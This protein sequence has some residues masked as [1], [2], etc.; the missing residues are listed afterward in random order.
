MIQYRSLRTILPAIVCLASTIFLPASQE[1]KLSEEQIKVFLRTAKVI[2]K[3]RTSTGVTSPYQLTLT[4]GTITHDAGFNYVNDFKTKMEFSDGRVENNFCDYYRYDIAAY[5]LAKLLGLDDMIPVTVERKALGEIGAISWWFPTKMNDRKRLE[6]KIDPPDIDAWNKQMYKKRVFAE[7]VYDN[8]PNLTNLLIS[9]DWQICM[10]DFTR[11]FR[12]HKAL[13]EVK[14]ISESMCERHLLERLRKL[15]RNEL[16]R[17]TKYLKTEYLNKAE[18]D[19][20]MARRDKIVAI[21]DELIAK[22]GE[23]EVLYDDSATKKGK[24]QV[25]SDSRQTLENP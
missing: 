21:F 4:D 5:E 18:I 2:A 25:H 15:D 6:N 20:V 9:E 19:G 24:K 22:K 12:Q 16:A 14:N 3:K 11:A 8:D 7:L 1:P 17:N 23:K 13:R 10:I